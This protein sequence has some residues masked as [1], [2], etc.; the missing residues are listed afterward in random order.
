MKK[1]YI[2]LFICVLGLFSLCSCEDPKY[3]EVF[4]IT[5]YFV[6]ELQTTYQSYGLIGGAK[7]TQYTN[8]REFKVFPMGRLINVRIEHAADDEEYEK[9]RSALESHYT[10]DERVQK[11]YRCQFGTIM[12]DCRN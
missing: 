4:E 8:N 6:E 12:V 2:T 9:L 1:I 11:V 5:D 7:Y 3:R 10:G